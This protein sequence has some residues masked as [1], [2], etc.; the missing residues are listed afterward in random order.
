MSPIQSV[1]AAFDDVMAVFNTSPAIHFLQSGNF[2]VAHYKSVLREIYHYTKEDPQL[3]ALAAVYFRGS[4]R[5]MVKLFLRH[6]ISEVGHDLA[7]LGDLEAL[8]E[9]PQGVY[10]ENPLPATTALTAFPFYWIHYQNPIGYLGY[11]YFLEHMPTQHGA[12]YANA[13]MGAGVPDAAM[14]FLKEHMHADVGHNK[15]MD[16][17]LEQLLHDQKD[18]DAVIYVMQVTAE[19]YANMLSAC[20]RRAETPMHYG[21]SWDELSRTRVNHQMPEGDGDDNNHHSH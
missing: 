4:D 3:Q 10:I 7:A 12:I 11:L 1:R 13:L 9:S 14:G 19:L 5:H 8:G 16:K 17:Y 20:V 6:A 2:T 21:Q 18:A 15:L